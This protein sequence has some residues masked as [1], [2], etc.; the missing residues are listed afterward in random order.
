VDF[1]NVGPGAGP[2]LLLRYADLDV[3]GQAAKLTNSAYVQAMRAFLG[4]A[5]KE[6]RPA[7]NQLVAP[8]GGGAD[9]FRVEFTAPSPLTSNG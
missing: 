9:V 5:N 2:G 3:N 1:G 6:I 4:N 8:A 7:S